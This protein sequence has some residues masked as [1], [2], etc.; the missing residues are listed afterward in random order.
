MGLVQKRAL[1]MPRVTIRRAMLII[2]LLAFG[3]FVGPMLLYAVWPRPR[4]TPGAGCINNLRNIAL[5]ILEFQSFNGVFPAGSWASAD[6]EPESRLSW[7]AQILPY[8]EHH[9]EYESL[10]TNQRWD[11]G[12]NGELAH[13]RFGILACYSAPRRAPGS[14]EPAPYVG[15]A[16][17][18]KDSPWIAKTDARAGVF[19]YERQTA[20]SDITDGAA[21]TMMVAETGRVSGSWL[22]A[23]PATVRGLDP[24]SQPYTGAGRQFGGQHGGGVLV[25]MADG[26]VR[27]IDA[28][29][30]A[31]VFEAISTMAGGEKM[32]RGWGQAS[33]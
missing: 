9:I 3:M 6:L 20:M 13:K 19:G 26:S 11:A 2:A 32:P 14:P 18:G 16:G 22:Q 5:G 4:E 8:I 31:K 30:S 29:I 12:Q 25:A 24:A 23:G 1:R 27:R 17:L 28:S 7:Y 15:I 21:N 10:E 33:P